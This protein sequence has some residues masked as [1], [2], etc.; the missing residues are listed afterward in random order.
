MP[1][2]KDLMKLFCEKYKKQAKSEHWQIQL[3]E[4][5]LDE[6]IAITVIQDTIHTWYQFRNWVWFR[7]FQKVRPTLKRRRV[8]E[9]DN[10]RLQDEITEHRAT[11]AKKDSV[12]TELNKNIEDKEGKIS[13]LKKKHE[14]KEDNSKDLETQLHEKED[15]IADLEKQVKMLQNT[16]SDVNA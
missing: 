13:D 4:Q 6:H 9:S 2:V 8:D 10:Q 12:I 5:K 15:N 11:I 16:I 14:A 7:L 1:V 3:I